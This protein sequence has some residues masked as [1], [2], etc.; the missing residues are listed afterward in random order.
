MYKKQHKFKIKAE[1]ACIIFM[2][3]IDYKKGD[4][5]MTETNEVL[6]KIL[7]E[8]QINGIE[9]QQQIVIGELIG[10]SLQFIFSLIILVIGIKFFR[11][12]NQDLYLREN[13]TQIFATMKNYKNTDSNYKKQEK[14]ENKIEDPFKEMYIMFKEW[15]NK[16]PIHRILI[17]LLL[18]YIEVKAFFFF[19]T[20]M[21]TQAIIVINCFVSPEKVVLDYLANLF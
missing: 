11:S 14:D 18:V 4:K 1:F 9:F 5:I 13:I 21:I 12:L 15:V 2:F 6:I 17:T 20:N 8:L 16:A 10:A 3:M 7:E 19:A